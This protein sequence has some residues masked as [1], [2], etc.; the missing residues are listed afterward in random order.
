VRLPRQA[1]AGLE[2]RIAAVEWGPTGAANLAGRCE[3]VVVVDVLRFTTAVDVAVSRRCWVEPAPARVD[4]PYSLLSPSVLLGVEPGTHLVV[5]SPNGAECARAAASGGAVVYAACLRNASAVAAAV[6]G[7][8]VGVV[9]AG[10]Q[11]GEGVLRPCLED[12]LGAGAVLYAL[13]IDCAEAA[14]FA[15]ARWDI[16]HQLWE[17][18]SGV[19]LREKGHADDVRL[20][21]QVDVSK[22]VPVLR[23]IRPVSA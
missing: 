9:P 22:T 3:A 1:R 20:A 21:A 11:W 19:E 13:G 6:R 4:S 18:P 23:E 5:P 17:C 14:A 10:E 7:R 12:L 16:E 15:W 8:S 2:G